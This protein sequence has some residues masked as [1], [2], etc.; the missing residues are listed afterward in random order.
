LVS[1]AFFGPA[2]GGHPGWVTTQGE[3]LASLFTAQ[4]TTALT[5]SDRLHPVGR[6]V[7]H[8]GDVVRWRRRV[9]VAVVSVFS[10]RAFALA[11]EALLLARVAGIPTVAWLHGGALPDFGAAHPRWVRRA[12]ARADAVVAPTPYLGRWAG[13]LGLE[14][15]VIPNVVDVDAVAFAPRAA[16]RPR[17]LWM[18]TFQELYRP[19]MAVEVLAELRS[20]GVDASLTMAGQD[21]GALAA[22]RD[23]AEALGVARWVTFPGFAGAAAKADLLRDHDVFLNTNDVDNAPVTVLEAAAAGLVVVATAVGG[24]PD[25]LADRQAALLVPRGDTSAMADAVVELLAD[26]VLA[27]RLSTAGRAVAEASAWP[28]VRERWLALAER[29]RAPRSRG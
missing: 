12:L 11:D 15:E 24:L 4:G 17:L 10:G 3:V 23:R 1:L 27:G 5:S 29:L 13:S 6:A 20:R 14:V 28:V 18:R 16:V 2:L 8:L 7:A 22:T 9:D 19:G 21:K 26:P 25:L